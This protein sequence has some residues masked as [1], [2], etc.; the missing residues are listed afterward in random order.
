M[1]RT[2]AQRRG[3]VTHRALRLSKA[4]GFLSVHLPLSSPYWFGFTKVACR[5]CRA[6]IGRGRSVG[7]FFSSH[8][9]EF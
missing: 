4:R 6:A 2:A 9:R 8:A 7:G 3:F 1:R 5:T